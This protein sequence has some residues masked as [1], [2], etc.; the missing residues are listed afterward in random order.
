MLEYDL[1]VRAIRTL[2]AAVVALAKLEPAA[3][4]AEEAEMRISEFEWM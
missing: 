1:S 3:V 2:P 4:A